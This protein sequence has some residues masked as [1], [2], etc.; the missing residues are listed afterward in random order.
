M[1]CS[2]SLS[3]LCSNYTC[4][5]R[6]RASGDPPSFFKDACPFRHTVDH[7]NVYQYAVPP[8]WHGQLGQF[9]RWF[10]GCTYMDSVC[11]SWM[12]RKTTTMRYTLHDSR[13]ET[14]EMSCK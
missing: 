7:R 11:Q 14:P 8:V 3:D 1:D 6:D 13:L 10:T 12:L 2:R 4:R 9:I 5:S